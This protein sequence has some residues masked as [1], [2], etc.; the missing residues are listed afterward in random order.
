MSPESERSP[1]RHMK[2]KPVVASAAAGLIASLCCGGSLIFVSMGLGAFFSALG[3]WRYV[4]QVLAAGA[5]TILAIDY[6]FYR[7]AAS[8]VLRQGGGVRELR[9]AMFMSAAI[10]LTL[11]A[12]SFVFLEWLNH[13]VVN[14]HRFLA[15]P[16]YREALVPGVPNIRLVYALASFMALA[17]LWALPFPRRASEQTW[18]TSTLRRVLRA[19][20]FVASAGLLIALLVDAVPRG[21]HGT[22]AA[23]QRSTSPIQQH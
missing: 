16:E 22:P 6:T 2:T 7:Q 9:R 20:V 10:G 3:L 4:P 11:M 1:I 14:P 17:L 12:G 5:L 23:G 19:G 15:R 8:S 18:S 21:G 13:A